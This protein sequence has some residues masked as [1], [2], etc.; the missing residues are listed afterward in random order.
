MSRRG[1]IADIMNDGPKLG[2][3]KGEHNA[4][5]VEAARRGVM[6]IATGNW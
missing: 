3:G 5:V 1:C 2:H 4:S 6:D